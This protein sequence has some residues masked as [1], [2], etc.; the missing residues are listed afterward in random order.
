MVS[1]LT[2]D[3]PLGRALVDIRAEVV[4]GR[5]G[6]W[7]PRTGSSRLGGASASRP[8]RKR[9]SRTRRAAHPNRTKGQ[10]VQPSSAPGFGPARPSVGVMWRRNRPR[11]LRSGSGDPR[12]D[13]VG[14]PIRPRPRHPSTQLRQRYWT[15]GYRS[16]GGRA[17]P[18][19][20][21]TSISRHWPTFRHVHTSTR[22]H[23]DSG[24]STMRNRRVIRSYS[25]GTR[26]PGLPPRPGRRTAPVKTLH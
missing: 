17:T 26:S 25:P 9:Q 6:W 23:I 12:R 21:T 20:L 3:W 15:C 7:S 10:A 2:S 13:W 24:E 18:V 11:R 8:G 14:D 19:A 5:R 4:V 22:P 16:A 1:L